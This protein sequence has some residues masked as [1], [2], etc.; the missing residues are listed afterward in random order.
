M[1]VV[2]VCF[3]DEAGSRDLC[4]SCGL[5]YLFIRQE[6]AYVFSGCLVSSQMCIRDS[7]HTHTHTHTHS[8]THAHTHTYTHAHTHT[9]THTPAHTTQ[10]THPMKQNPYIPLVTTLI[11]IK[12][13][14][15]HQLPRPNYSNTPHPQSN[16][17]NPKYD[18]QRHPTTK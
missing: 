17:Q 8:H 6:T 15:T 10:L 9:H 14:S 16:K 12:P 1:Y 13:C 11:H 18:Q 4:M 2:L 3:E 5:G 7:T